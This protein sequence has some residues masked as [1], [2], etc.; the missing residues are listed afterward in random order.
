MTFVSFENIK[1]PEVAQKPSKVSQER[2]RTLN[3]LYI[4]GPV[5]PSQVCN[6]EH[7]PEPM[8]APEDDQ[9]AVEEP[10]R[11]HGGSGEGRKDV[12]PPALQPSQRP[13]VEGILRLS[14]PDI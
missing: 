4:S 9:E 2:W 10:D 5:E 8:E 6:L 11:G 1:M 13:G 3:P 7:E 12:V 14:E